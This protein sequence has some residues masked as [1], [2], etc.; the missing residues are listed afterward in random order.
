[1]MPK[2]IAAEI[3]IIKWFKGVE[4]NNSPKYYP[5]VGSCDYDEHELDMWYLGDKAGETYGETD[6]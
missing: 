1:M 5:P 6:V 2:P 3:P 4:T